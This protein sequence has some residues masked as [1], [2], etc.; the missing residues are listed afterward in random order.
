MVSCLYCMPRGERPT[1]RKAAM[2]VVVNRTAID[3][4]L[5]AFYQGTIIQHRT[6]KED[7]P[8]YKRADSATRKSCHRT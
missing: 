7:Y 6:G 1:G 8:E 3:T 2:Q 4:T 5:T